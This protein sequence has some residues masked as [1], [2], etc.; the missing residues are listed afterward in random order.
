MAQRVSDDDILVALKKS[1]TM[2]EAGERVRLCPSRLRNRI[3]ALEIQLGTPLKPGAVP[4]VKLKP[5]ASAVEHR[6]KRDIQELNRQLRDAL[7]Q[8]EK[9]KTVAQIVGAVAKTNLAPPKWLA[10]KIKKGKQERAIATAL[11][12]DT[13]FD[14]VVDP[15]Q[16]NNVNAYNREIAVMRLKNF[17]R[18]VVK[19]SEE[20]IN[21]I[22]IDGLVLPLG[23]DIV[24]GDIHMELKETNE[25]TIIETVLFWSEQIA[26]GVKMLAEVFPN[27]YL[28]CV[29][30][31]HGRM[32]KKPRHKFRAQTNMD[33]LLYHMVARELRHLSNVRFAISEGADCRYNVY[34]TRYLL[35]HGDQYRGGSGIAG[36]LSP[37]MLGDH[38]KRK[39]EAATGHPFEYQIMGHWHQ[40][41]H[42][43]GIIVNGSLKGYDEYAA[44]SNFDYEPPRQ[45]FWLTDSE[46]GKT[47]DAPIHVTD[48]SEKWIADAPEVIGF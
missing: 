33:Y 19:L 12:S 17:F 39:R 14:E 20:Y 40:L 45:A 43:R 18:N 7:E 37:L 6:Y 9:S 11:L 47:I 44:N 38:R 4:E 3:R 8:L 41:A 34:N 25:A 30:G 36:M 10:P 42:V 23:G 26:A 5:L 48:K 2:I 22:T 28:P 1:K 31:N 29:V 46:W 13:H 21:G 24:G 32:D 35:T 16:I 15:T 27:I